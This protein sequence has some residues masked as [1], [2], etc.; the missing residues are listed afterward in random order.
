MSAAQALAF[1]ERHGVVC[2]A[3]R[4]GA[5]SP[6][7]DAVA[8]EPVRGNWWSHARSREIFA[9]TRTVRDS[10]DVLV[11]RL[12]DG[13]ITFVHRRLWAAMV[14]LVDRIDMS[15]LARLREVHSA[16]GKHIVEEVPFPQWVPRS[17]AFE[18]KGLSEMEALAALG[19]AHASCFP[20]FV[21]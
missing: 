19:D 21:G 10:A 14:R 13:K 18:A 5:I 7:V 6:L 4:R 12:V 15:R 11:C 9:A 17:V 16:S 2:E 1:V 8:G 20:K 3:A